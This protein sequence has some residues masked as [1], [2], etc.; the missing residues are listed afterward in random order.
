[1]TLLQFVAK[2]DLSKTAVRWNAV[3]FGKKNVR[4]KSPQWWN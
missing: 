2:A 1:M 4:Q 3:I